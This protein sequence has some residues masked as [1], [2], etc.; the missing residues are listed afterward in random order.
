MMKV[1]LQCVAP[2]A[3]LLLAGACSET[4]APAAPTQVPLP[5][6]TVLPRITV[7]EELWELT[8]TIVS[9]E[10]SACFWTHPVGATF[11]S[12]TLSVERSG[13]QVRFTYDVNNPHD[14]VLLEGAV[15][16]LS[17][18]AVSGASRG[19]WRCSGNLT[20][21]SS[22]VGSFSSDGRSLSGR[23]RQMY[24]VDGGGELIVTLE[25]NAARI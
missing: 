16:E 17:F 20:F 9:L 18:T 23:E 19:G 1:A 5:N 8:T 22:V 14:N 10:G 11:D 24:R 13:T 2:V 21:S 15:N 12:W 25:W 3:V 7:V 6:P 4:A